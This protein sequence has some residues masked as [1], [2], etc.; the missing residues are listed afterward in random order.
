MRMDNGERWQGKVERQKRERNTEEEY[1]KDGCSSVGL[2]TETCEG[3]HMRCAV[4]S[5]QSM[6]CDEQGSVKS[7]GCMAMRVG[8]D[9]LEAKHV[10]QKKRVRGSMRWL[11]GHKEGCHILEQSAHRYA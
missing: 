8:S 4:W 3:L 2:Q 1:Q 5:R 7:V 11:V 10:G 6:W 9:G